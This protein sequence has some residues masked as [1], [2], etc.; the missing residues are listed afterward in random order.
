MNPVEIET[1]SAEMN[2]RR[3]ETPTQLLLLCSA[4]KVASTDPVPLA[5]QW[6]LGSGSRER[7]LVVLSYLQTNK[8]DT[9]LST[10]CYVGSSTSSGKASPT[11]N[12][13][14]PSVRLSPVALCRCI[15]G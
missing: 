4:F 11:V 15:L 3:M 5:L 2:G 6:R 10:D 9:R 13:A 7:G 1:N 14:V 12:I 8:H